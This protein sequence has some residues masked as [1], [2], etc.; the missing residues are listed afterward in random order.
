MKR[1][2]MGLILSLLALVAPAQSVD[3]YQT[4]RQSGAGFAEV[5]PGRV[6]S[7][8]ADHLPHPGYRIEW[9]YLTGNLADGKGRRWGIQWTLFRSQQSPDADPG[10]W[11]SNVV[12][13]AHAAVTTPDGHRHAR[14]YARG[15]IGQAGVAQRDGRFRA[16]LDDWQLLAQGEDMFPA[17]LDFEAEGARVT[18]DIDSATPY[19]LQGAAGFSQKSAQGQASYYYSQPH[20]RLNGEV[21]IDGERVAVSGQGWLDREWSSQP[22]ADNQQGWDWFSLHL[23]DGHALMVYRLRHDDGKHWLS[24]SWVSLA[25]EST[26][27]GPDDI[28]LEVLERR[29]VK[30]PDPQAPEARR[31]L[32][33]RW[34]IK[35]P[36]L[37]KSWIVE[38]ARD[39]QWMGGQF[40]YWE[41]VVLV[42]EGRDGV[43]YLELTG[44]PAR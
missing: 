33:L 41:G 36:R 37:G 40:P 5:T 12:W 44:Y 1:W 14:R 34:T 38:A 23:A 21:V 26:P 7:F 4:L 30:T 43:G 2:T 32:P 11:S 24:G 31:D 28:A 25:G 42:N 9:W 20:L 6:F 22:L 10:G 19:V 29:E 13:M 35:L 16:W 3:P 17:R 8:P 18:L 27:L 39:D 15:G